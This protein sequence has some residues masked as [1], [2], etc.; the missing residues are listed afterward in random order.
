MIKQFL[1]QVIPD[2]SHTRL[3]VEEEKLVQDLQLILSA[4]FAAATLGPQPAI[5]V[6]GLNPEQA[7]SLLRAHF[8]ARTGL[9]PKI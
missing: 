3:I 6:V 5:N 9:E 4:Y 1:V 8:Q 7:I 2:D